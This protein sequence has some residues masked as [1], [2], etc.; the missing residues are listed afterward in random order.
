L[1]A[2][3][4]LLLGSLHRHS[5]GVA[6]KGWDEF[7][8]RTRRLLIVG[9]LFEGILK[10]AALIDLVRRPTSEVRGSKLRWV[11]A[12]TLINSLG[13]VSIAYF[14]RGSRRPSATAR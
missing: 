7:S 5:G 11:L 2:A 6:R 13:A 9:A 12:T 14:T 3:D 10:I 1:S 4:R 8:A